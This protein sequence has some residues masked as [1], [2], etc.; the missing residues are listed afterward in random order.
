M[1]VADVIRACE[2][3][4]CIVVDAL[5]DEIDVSLDDYSKTVEHISAKDNQVL[6]W[7]FDNFDKLEGLEELREFFNTEK[8]GKNTSNIWKTRLDLTDYFNVKEYTYE[9]TTS[10]L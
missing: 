3:V 6:I 1:T 4:N 10:R 8:A 5:G 9:T 7:T 2:Y